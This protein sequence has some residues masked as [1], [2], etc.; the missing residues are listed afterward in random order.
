MGKHYF[1]QWETSY[2][3][4]P[5][6]QLECSG[7]SEGFRKFNIRELGMEIGLQEEMLKLALHRMHH[8]KACCGY[9]DVEIL[10]RLAG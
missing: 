5:K 6:N 3:F 1:K 4:A 2:R 8:L 10:A 9:E 7:H